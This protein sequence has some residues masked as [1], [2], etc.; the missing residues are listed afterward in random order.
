MPFQCAAAHTCPGP[1]KVPT[2]QMLSG[3]IAEAACGTSGEG[4]CSQRRPVNRTT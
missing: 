2:V 1:V 4:T 3:A